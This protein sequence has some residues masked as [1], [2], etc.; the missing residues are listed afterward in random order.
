M[1]NSSHITIDS[2][3]KPGDLG[4]VIHLHGKLYKQEYG[5]SIDFE[6]YVSKGLSEFYDQYDDQKD[7]V[8]VARN[9]DEIAGFLLLKHRDNNTAQLRYFIIQPHYRG[10]GLGKRLMESFMNFLKEKQYQS[11]Y[12]WTTSELYTAAALYKKYGFVLTE[13][14]QSDGFGKTVIEQRYNWTA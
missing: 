14:K 3:L 6:N 4:Y 10:F 7:K 11:C 12:L 5:Y 13:E 8:W 9:N 2:D 1:T